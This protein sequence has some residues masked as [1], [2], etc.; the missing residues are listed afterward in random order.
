[1]RHE[2]Q[3]LIEEECRKRIKKNT[4]RIIRQ[5]RKQL[6][7][8]RLTG[9]REV[10]SSK[11]IPFIWKEDKQFNPY[12]VLANASFFA[13][14]VTKS[15]KEGRYQPKPSLTFT[16]RKRDS[17]KNRELNMFSIVDAAVAKWVNNNLLKNNIAL[18]SP[19]A[20][21]YRKDKNANHA[22]DH[23]HFA[24][25]EHHKVFIGEYDF[26]NFHDTIE[27]TKLLEIV[28]SRFTTSITERLIIFS[29]LTHAQANAYNYRRK[30]FEVNTTGLPQ[31]SAISMTLSN[32]YCYP[33]DAR[34]EKS[35]ASFARYADDIVFI[36]EDAKIAN[37]CENIIFD[38]AKNSGLE[39]SSNKSNGISSLINNPLKNQEKFK[40]D[41]DFLG[42]KIAKNISIADKSISRIK[43]K[44]TKIVNE[45]LI[46]YP[47]NKGFSSKRYL[48]S[49][50]ID[51][52]Y[53][54]CIHSIRRYIY[55][56]ISEAQLSKCLS[57]K[58]EPIR[59][60][61][62]LLTYFPLVNNGDLFKKL[63]GWLCY[64]LYYALKR[65]CELLKDYLPNY[66]VPAKRDLITGEWYKGKFPRETTIPS[67]F[68]SWLYV[69]EM[70]KR[71][72][73]LDQFSTK[74]YY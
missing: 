27:H 17:G 57:D 8:E 43:R 44:I 52:D 60:A 9:V 70:R 37:H 23:L 64:T 49:L 62:N 22:I 46:Y 67:F 7:I 38:E 69:Q 18:L 14:N 54:A 65:R 12:Y 34:L 1:M 56:N 21:A 42:H 4:R 13:S 71:G 47:K 63:D 39:V 20:F 66:Y 5:K 28:K 6:H 51:W 19:Y 48:S 58:S 32:M 15:I 68:R 25:T 74:T 33:L 53:I 50:Q 16:I 59:Y 30:I 10:K 11:R 61:K 24:A 45:H 2:I 3:K 29:F 40:P 73:R 35:G 36:A 31:G 55:G 26:S 41:F 72:R